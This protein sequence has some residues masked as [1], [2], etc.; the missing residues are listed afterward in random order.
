VGEDEL[1]EQLSELNAALP[2]LHARQG[3]IERQIVGVKLQ[4]RSIAKELQ[5]LEAGKANEELLALG[6]GDGRGR[7]AW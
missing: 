1:R 2:E 6:L 5:A 3:D 7:G 4:I